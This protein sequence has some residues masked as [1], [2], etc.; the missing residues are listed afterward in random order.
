M[1]EKLLGFREGRR[2]DLRESGA[3]K[4]GSVRV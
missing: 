2:L 3:T 4:Q 1:R